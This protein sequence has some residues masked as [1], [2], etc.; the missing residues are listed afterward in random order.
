MKYTI[1]TIL[2][3]LFGFSLS[4]QDPS[5]IKGVLLDADQ[6]TPLLYANI[7]VLHKSQGTI[8]NEKG[9]FSLDISKLNEK[10]TI[11]FQ[12][13]GYKTQLIVLSELDSGSTI[14]LKED[15]INLSEAFVF[16]NPPDPKFI[17]K[18]VL[19]NKDKNYKKRTAKAQ[20]FIRWRNT[21]DI[22]KATIDLKKNSIKELDEASLKRAAEKIPKHNTSYVDFLGDIFVSNKDE[23]TLKINPIRIVS[24]KGEEIAELEQMGE[25]FENLFT[26]EDEKEYWKVKSGILSQKLD[27][28]E[29]ENDSIDQEEKKEN[30]IRTKRYST[31][32]K[33][34]LS[35]SSLGNKDYWDFLHKTGKYNYELAGGTK[36]N[37]EDVFIIDFMPKSSGLYEGR[38]YIS[39]STYALIRADYNYAEGKVGRDFNLLGVAFKEN[40]F[41]GSIY[42]EKEEDHY[43]LKYFSYKS[44]NYFSVERKISLIKKRKRLLFDKKLKEIKVGLNF[45]VT[46]GESIEV[47]LLNN[48]KISHQQFMDF[49]QPKDMEIIYVDHFDENLWKGFPIIEPTK[50]MRE[51]TKPQD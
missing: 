23:D 34:R 51:Y 10:D 4:A 18:K 22:E 14:Y 39:M 33:Y 42:F 2:L 32:I 27:I 48:K 49:D 11:S 50:R 8:S 38:L 15:L 17:V 35:Y 7:V 37:G 47:L 5:L 13:I 6:K 29:P 45:Q 46:N 24:L 28:D 16:A 25:V 12:Y 19:E 40:Y 41:S 3:F 9:M 31:N 1:I 21:S 36:V 30:T 44:G 20:T 26:Q 43:V